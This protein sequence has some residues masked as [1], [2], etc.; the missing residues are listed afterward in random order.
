MMHISLPLYQH[1]S[2]ALLG[3]TWKKMK[4]QEQDLHYLYRYNQQWLEHR[5]SRRELTHSGAT[6]S[7]ANHQRLTSK[8]NLRVTTVIYATAARL[9]P[10]AT[11]RGFHLIIIPIQTSSKAAYQSTAGEHPTLV[12]VLSV[13]RYRYRRQRCSF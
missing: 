6:R 10:G 7:K 2:R 3:K 1:P 5:T 12:S 13:H 9:Q 11:S 8:L 4:N